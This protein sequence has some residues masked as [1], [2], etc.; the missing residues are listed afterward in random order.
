MFN[1]KINP[2]FGSYQMLPAWMKGTKQ[3]LNINE[4][5]TKRY[6]TDVSAVI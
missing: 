6:V 5:E 3:F 2:Q 4:N 1:Y